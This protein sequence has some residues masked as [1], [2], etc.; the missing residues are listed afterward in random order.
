MA[1]TIL[2]NYSW[3]GDDGL[4]L[5]EL[6]VSSFMILVSLYLFLTWCDYSKSDL[7]Y[8]H[9]SASV[10]NNVYELT[11]GGAHVKCK[12]YQGKWL[13]QSIA[14]KEVGQNFISNY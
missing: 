6:I 10:G 9:Y 1:T 4:N 3:L 8:V 13:R 12:T 7:T 11:Y 5:S 14:F 2:H